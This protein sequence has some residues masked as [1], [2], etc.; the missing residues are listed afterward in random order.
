MVGS[1]TID[2]MKG[3]KYYVVWKGRKTGIFSNWEEAEA[4]VKGYEGAQYKSFG[5]LSEATEAF[6]RDYETY[7]GSPSSRGRWKTAS[8]KP[9]LPCICV[10]AACSGPPGPVEY[11]GISLPDGREIFCKGPFPRGTNN[12]GEFLAIV[13]ALTWLS[14]QDR[15]MPVYSDSQTAIAWVNT[16]EAKTKLDHD[17]ISA[18]LFALIHSAENWLAENKLEDDAVQKWD[19]DMWGEIPADFGRK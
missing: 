9:V 18:P 2:L 14:K 6:S 13:H 3:Q 12:I 5:L 15:K 8:V 16:G 7:R 10:D 11:R 4:Q 1:S 19:T 17:A